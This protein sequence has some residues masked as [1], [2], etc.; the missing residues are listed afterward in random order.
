[1][2]TGKKVYFDLKYM[3]VDENFPRLA[4]FGFLV[5]D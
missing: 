4:T 2:D 1:V 5:T 3:R